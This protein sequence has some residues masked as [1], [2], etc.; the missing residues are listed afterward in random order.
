M[1]L[2]RIFTNK[3]ESN[4]LLLYNG[5]NLIETIKINTRRCLTYCSVDQPRCDGYSTF[6]ISCFPNVWNQTWHQAVYVAP[7]HDF[8]VRK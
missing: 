3:T 4:G 8:L 1:Y 6:A 2:F 5:N 7:I